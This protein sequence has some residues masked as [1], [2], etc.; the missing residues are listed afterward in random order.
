MKK[1][2]A[3]YF[4]VATGISAIIVFLLA[5]TK[6]F[7][8]SENVADYI[9]PFVPFFNELTLLNT[10]GGVVVS[11]LWGWVLGYFFMLL[12]NWIDRRV[13]KSAN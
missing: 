10:I 12:Y 1:Y 2:D 8:Y 4:G 3:K 6:M 11:F 13:V 9:K 5:L 7:F